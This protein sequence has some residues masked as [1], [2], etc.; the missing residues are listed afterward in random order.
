MPGPATTG[1]RPGVTL[2]RT[3]SVTVTQRGA[4][5]TGLEIDGTLLIEASDVLVEDCLIKAGSGPVAVRIPYHGVSG[6]R[7]LHV[8]IDGGRRDPSV[9]GIAGSAF[10]VDAADIH[11][12]GDGIDAGS[13]VV[14]ENSWIHD[15]EARAGDHTDGV[16][17]TGGVGLR[18]VNNTI[19]ATGPG[20]NSAIIVG[21]DLAPLDNVVIAHNL[22]DGGNYTI[23]AGAGDRFESGVIRVI[24]NR[25]GTNAQ[26]GSCSL[27]PSPGHPI[28]FSGN[29]EDGTGQAMRC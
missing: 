27:K 4:R 24:D 29:V 10:T 6:V 20:I 14:I 17:S 8:E 5:L 15:L 25:F 11:G 23:Y 26:Y 13:N 2:R 19:D 18:I 28:D 1:V 7:L 3:G 21:A 22:L 16:Q 9:V 12:T